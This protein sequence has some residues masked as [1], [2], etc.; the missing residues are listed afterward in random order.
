MAGDSFIAKILSP[1][2]GILLIPFTRFVIACLFVVTTTV[3]VVGV[4]RVHMFILSFL[5]AGMWISLG[6]F[7]KAY[8][9]AFNGPESEAKEEKL[10]PTRAPAVSQAK[11]ED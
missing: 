5:S 9:A 7:H 8:T 10:P 4:A 6:I 3:L 1:G 2:G 11:R